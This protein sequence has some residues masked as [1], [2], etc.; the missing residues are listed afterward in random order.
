LCS[1]GWIS[2]PQYVSA[3][4]NA[5]SGDA[6]FDKGQTFAMKVAGGFNSNA[7]GVVTWEAITSAAGT[8]LTSTITSMLNVGNGQFAMDGRM[9]ADLVGATNYNRPEEIETK[10]M[11]GQ[12]V[13][14]IVTTGSHEVYSL[15][16]ASNEMRIFVSRSTINSATGLPVG[17]ELTSPDNVEI[18]TDGNVYIVEDQP[19]GEADIWFATDADRDG[20]AESI[21]RWAT[22]STAGAEPTGLYFDKFNPNVAYVNVM[23]PDSGNDTMVQITASRFQKQ[24]PTP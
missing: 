8:P 7:V 12:E 13:I 3:N 6:F 21:G 4:P 23:H 9:A 16:L 2:Y 15:N 19:G 22:M 11:N 18:D 14:F 20:V 17:T 24:K 10:T 5:I 1:C